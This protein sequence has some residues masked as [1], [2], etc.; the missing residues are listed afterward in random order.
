MTQRGISLIEVLVAL[1]IL[2][3]TLIAATRVIGQSTHRSLWLQQ[4]IAAEA[5]IQNQLAPALTLPS[6]HDGTCDEQP[7]LHWSIA[8]QD[9]PAD[10]HWTLI[11][12]TIKN[13]QGRMIDQA[14]QLTPHPSTA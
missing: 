8:T 1:A 14:T 5:C 9:W 3:I 12:I 10:T 13:E 7:Q 11:T 2:S 6:A 4:H